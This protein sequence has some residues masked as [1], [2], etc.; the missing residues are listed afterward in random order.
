VLQELIS[1]LRKNGRGKI[2]DS[3][4]SNHHV[5]SQSLLTECIFEYQNHRPGIVL[6]PGALEVLG[7]NK[8]MP[9]YL[10][11]DGNPITQNN[12]VDALGIR[13]FFSEV[14]TTWSLGQEFAKPSLGVFQEIL[15]RENSTFEKLVYVA[16]DPNKDFVAL[17]KAGAITVRVLTGRFS[18]LQPRVGFDAKFTIPDI[19]QFD[20]SQYPT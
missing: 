20:I 4:L 14:F 15:R 7:D 3:V 1:E 17:N 8:N 13:N 10:V 19:S 9:K 11:T 2:F 12:K 16:D 5:F 18:S 6:F